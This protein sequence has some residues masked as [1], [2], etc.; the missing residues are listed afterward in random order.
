LPFRKTDNLK[1]ESMHSKYNERLDFGFIVF[2]ILFCILSSA[3]ISLADNDSLPAYKGG[4]GMVTVVW[5]TWLKH[6][7]EDEGLA[8][9][10]RI[11]TDMTRFQGYV[12]HF[13]LRDEDEKGHLLVVSEWTSREAADRTRAQYANAEPVKLITPLLVKQRNRW[14]FSKD[15]VTPQK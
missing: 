7:S 5:E 8:L 2:I 4:S 15:P 1:G 13:I 9:T 12:S 6:G 3:H 11:W 10:R 14:V